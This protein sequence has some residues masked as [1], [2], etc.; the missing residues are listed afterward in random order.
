MG[1]DT[2]GDDGVRADGGPAR[3]LQLVHAP[4]HQGV[5]QAFRGRRTD[6]LSGPLAPGVVDQAGAL[7]VD[8][9]PQIGHGGAQPPGRDGGSTGAP[10]PGIERLEP[11]LDRRQR[12]S[13]SCRLPMPEPPV[14]AVEQAADRRRAGPSPRHACPLLAAAAWRFRRC[15]F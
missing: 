12:P 13:P 11:A 15:W 7:A 1:I 10:A 14:Q 5:G 9:L 4:V 3:L 6:R 8:I 2:H